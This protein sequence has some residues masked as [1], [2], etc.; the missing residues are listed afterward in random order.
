M[1]KMNGYEL[2]RFMD[3]G[4]LYTLMGRKCI[5]LVDNETKNGGVIELQDCDKAAGEGSFNDTNI[6]SDINVHD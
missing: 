3:N 6:L 2:F 4:G 5:S 1:R